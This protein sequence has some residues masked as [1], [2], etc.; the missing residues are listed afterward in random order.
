MSLDVSG[1]RNVGEFYSE[2]YLHAVLEGDLKQVFKEWV[3]REREEG[4][5]AKSPV[6]RLASLSE[7]FFR[8]QGRAEDARGEGRRVERFEQARSFHARLLEALGYRYAP[9]LVPL[10]AGGWVPLLCLEER[11]GRPFLYVIDAPWPETEEDDPLDEVPLPEQVP[12]EAG[13]GSEE[14]PRLAEEKNPPSR[15]PRIL[16]ATQ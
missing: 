13:G 8:A 14:A 11:S 3:A 2:H 1:V 7:P 9:T 16:V 4:S 5:A 12:A 10:E 6:K 15:L